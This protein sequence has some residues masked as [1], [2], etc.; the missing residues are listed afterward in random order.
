MAD[1]P[2]VSVPL[3]THDSAREWA[4]N[5]LLAIEEMLDAA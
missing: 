2:I 4:N 1:A 3:T 5:S